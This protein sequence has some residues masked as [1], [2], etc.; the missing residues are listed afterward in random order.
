MDRYLCSVCKKSVPNQHKVICC[1]HCN[2]WVYIICNNLHDLDYNLLKSKNDSWYCILCTPEIIPLGQINEKMSI[3]KEN[4]NKPTDALVNLKSQLNN[5]TDD[6]KENKLNLSNCKYGDPDYFKN[7]TKDFK[8]TA[9]SFFHMNVCL[10]TKNFDGFNILISEL[11]VIFDILAITESRIKKDS[12]C[13]IN[14]Q[15]N[16]YSTEHTPT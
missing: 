15:L 4:L 6:E 7:L 11:N 2:Q 3:P 16:N 12:S 9:L 5:F 14:L 8:R 1:D 13:P 10:L